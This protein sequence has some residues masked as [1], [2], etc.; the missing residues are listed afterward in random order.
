[1]QAAAARVRVPL[2]VSAGRQQPQRLGTFVSVNHR[3]ASVRLREQTE[4]TAANPPE[5]MLG[6]FAQKL[7]VELLLDK[8]ALRACAGIGIITAS[9]TCLPVVPRQGPLAGVCELWDCGVNPHQA[10]FAHPRG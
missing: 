8:L 2:P 5:G 6:T 3:L 4:R 10:R 7:R 9:W 1:M